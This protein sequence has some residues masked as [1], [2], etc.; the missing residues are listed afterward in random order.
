[1]ICIAFTLLLWCACNSPSPPA[2]HT[3]PITHTEAVD[4]NPS[5]SVCYLHTHNKDSVKLRFTI[6]HR[7]IEGKIHFK[8]YQ[9][10]GSQG[11]VRGRFHGDTLFVLYDFVAEG[12]HN[13]T[14]EAFLKRGDTYVRG[15]GER[16]EIEGVHRFTEKGDVD[17]SDG[18]VFV[19][20][21]C[22]DGFGDL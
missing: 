4:V 5:N 22:T 10:D 6:D 13:V 18:Q 7:S 3:Q 1:M 19:P 21:Q 8:N 11:A 16:E 12:T 9:I 17:F 2:D 20:V 15:F 14:E